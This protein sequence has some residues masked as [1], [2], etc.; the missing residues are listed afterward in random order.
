MSID[1]YVQVA[2][3]EKAKRVFVADPSVFLSFPLLSPLGYQPE[4]LA[5]LAAPSTPSDFAAAADFARAVNFLPR[6]MVASGLGDRYLW[7]IYGEVLTRAEVAKGDGPGTGPGGGAS[8]LYDVAPGGTRTE[9]AVYRAYRQYRD[10]WIVARE[11]YGAH[12]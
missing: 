8:L 3:I 6:D 9:S 11:D 5:A 2:L 7:D 12:K 1:A 10:A 4:T